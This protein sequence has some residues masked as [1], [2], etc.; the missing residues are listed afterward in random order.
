MKKISCLIIDDEPLALLLIDGYVNKTPF[1]ELK[2]K[3]NNAFE[4]LDLLSKVP[5]DLIFLDIQMPDL[6]GID[7]STKLNERTRVVFTTAFEEYALKGYKVDALDYLLKPFNYDD[8]LTAALKAQKWFG[9][10]DTPTENSGRDENDYIFV[11]SEYKQVKVFLT[12]ILYIE[13]LKDYVKIYRQNV[14]KPLLSLMSLKSLDID[15][16]EDMFMRVH[17]SFI[18]GLK[19]INTIERN[20]II[21]NDVRITIAEPY[22]EKFHAYLAKKSIR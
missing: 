13:G 17:R 15:L 8:F 22:R 18:V 16:P 5:V 19:K 2:G 12:D 6:N 20:Q 14:S 11:K 3:C 4:A 1:L 9:L 10:I 7:L 21:I